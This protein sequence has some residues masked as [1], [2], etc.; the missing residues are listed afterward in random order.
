MEPISIPTLHTDRLTLTAMEAAH[1]RGVFELWSHPDVCRYSGQVVDH[2][3]N[4]IRTPCTTESQSDRI[5][6]FWVR[7]ARDGWGFRWSILGREPGSGIFIGMVGF[8]AIAP[9][10]EIAFHLH[11]RFWG[12]GYMLEA[13]NEAME[14]ATTN[15]C[16]HQFKAFIE[17][18]NTKAIRLA[19]RLGFSATGR[20]RSRAQQY[21]RL[22][23]G[24]P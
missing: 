22:G 17:D 2:D 5:I 20:Y 21:Q 15:L 8:N 13:T 1:S 23:L 12:N 16:S 6:E 10:P 24:S 9:I 3:G 4:V 14:W 18:G 7:A 19:T 11:P